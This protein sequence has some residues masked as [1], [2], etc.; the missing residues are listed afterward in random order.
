MLPCAP[1][2]VHC[3]AT[4]LHSC[5]RGQRFPVCHIPNG[6]DG[7][8]ARAA[9]VLIHLQPEPHV[10]QTSG[11]GKNKNNTKPH[12]SWVRHHIANRPAPQQMRCSR[13]RAQRARPTSIAPLSLN[14]TPTFSRPKPEDLGFRPVAK[15]TWSTCLMAQHISEKQLSQWSTLPTSQEAQ[16]SIDPTCTIRRPFESDEI[17][18]PMY[19]SDDL[20]SP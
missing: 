10:R 2:Q 15:S 9:A 1:E 13:E 6:P 20:Q 5:R 12:H 14:L 7:R 4:A 8:H 16:A 19:V 3:N 17:L 18:S 11:T